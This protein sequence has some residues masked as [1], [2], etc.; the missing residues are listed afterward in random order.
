MILKRKSSK[1]YITNANP[2]Y[3]PLVIVLLSKSKFFGSIIIALRL[4]FEGNKDM[5]K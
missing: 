4:I 3:K 5:R 2:K 1:E